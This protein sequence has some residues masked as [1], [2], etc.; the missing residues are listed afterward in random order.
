MIHPQDRQKALEFHTS[1]IKGA[2]KDVVE[3]EFRLR[4]QGKS[5]EC[6]NARGKIFMRNKNGNVYEYI[7]LLRNV[8][9]EKRT[10]QALISA[11]KLSIKGEIARTLAHELRNPLASIGMTA[12]I[13]EKVNKGRG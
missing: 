1:I 11:E 2:D 12:D 7:V 10:Q 6:Y 13:L 4:S 3:I 8:Q 9:S 5:W